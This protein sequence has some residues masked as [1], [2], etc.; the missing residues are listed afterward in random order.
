MRQKNESFSNATNTPLI[1]LDHFDD[2]T[3]GYLDLSL[4]LS[5]FS[6]SVIEGH[7][8]EAGALLLLLLLKE[9]FRLQNTSATVIHFP[10]CSEKNKSYVTFSKSTVPLKRRKEVILCIAGTCVLY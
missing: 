9:M 2:I 5:F 6:G 10:N 1:F 3:N 8:E 4:L 7:E